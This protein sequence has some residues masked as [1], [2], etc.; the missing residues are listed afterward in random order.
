MKITITIVQPFTQKEFDIQ[1]NHTQ[2]IRSTLQVLAE[3]VPELKGVDQA[4]KIRVRSTGRQYSTDI[5]YEH[6]GI[7]T[8]AVIT[9]VLA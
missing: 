5:T 4:K 8:G 9:P 3:A 1:V 2:R 6:A 7:Y